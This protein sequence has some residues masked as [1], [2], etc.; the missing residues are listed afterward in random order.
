M[1]VH[2]LLRSRTVTLGMTQ[3]GQAGA[4]RCCQHSDTRLG[5]RSNT[6]GSHTLECSVSALYPIAIAL[7]Y[8]LP[9]CLI[10]FP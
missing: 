10:R 1:E 7:H 5:V 2:Q 4:V 6:R 3:S 9:T 8:S